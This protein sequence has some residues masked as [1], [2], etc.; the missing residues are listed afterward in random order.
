M[1]ANQAPTVSVA[2]AP[3][4]VP[5]GETVTLTGT[6]SDP[7]VP[8]VLTYLWS[9]SVEGGSFADST[10]LSTTWMAPT[11]TG[12]DDV[13][14]TLTLTVTDD[15]DNT[16]SDSVVVTVLAPTQELKAFIFADPRTVLGNGMLDLIGTFSGALDADSVTH[17]WTATNGTIAPNNTASTVW[18]APAPT[19]QE[20]TITVTLTVTEGDQTADAS[21]TITVLANPEPMVN[22]WVPSLEVNGIEAVTFDFV[23]VDDAD[24]LTFGWVDES[25]LGS[26]DDSGIL[27][28]T[29]TAPLPSRAL[30]STVL[31]LTVTDSV[32]SIERSVD[33]EVRGN[34][35][36]TLTIHAPE[37]FFGGQAQEVS[38][39]A[40]DPENDPLS[41]K[42]TTEGSTV[43]MFADDA[44]A[45]T[46][47]TA[48]PAGEEDVV[49]DLVVTVEDAVFVPVPDPVIARQQI[50]V[51]KNGAPDVMI[52][53]T[54]NIVAGG[55]DVGLDAEATRVADREGDML[56]YQWSAV[57]SVGTFRTFAGE[58]SP[59]M[60]WTAPPAKRDSQ[61]VTLTLT[62]TD[63]GAGTRSTSK[64]VTV[65]VRADEAPTRPDDLPTR[66]D[67]NGGDEE[68]L[69]GTS[70]TDV[71]G[72]AWSTDVGTFAGGAT[73]ATGETPTWTAPGPDRAGASGTITL[74][75]TDALGDTVFTIPVTVRAD[76]APTGSVSA[77][78]GTVLGGTEVALVAAISDDNP[79]ELTYR[80]T[81]NP[82]VGTFS[83]DTAQNTSWTAPAATAADRPVTFTLTVTDAVGDTAFTTMV[84]VQQNQPPA[85][86]LGDDRDVVGETVV[87]LAPVVSDPEGDML[88]HAWTADPDVGT[89]ANPLAKDTTWTAPAAA[90]DA[91]AVVLTLTVTDNGAGAL[92][93]SDSLTVTVRPLGTT[94]LVGD[95]R[96][97]PGFA[98][99]Y[100]G[101]GG[102]ELRWK[103]P[104]RVPFSAA[105]DYDAIGF[106]GFE[107]QFRT[108]PL[109][110]GW[111][112][113]DDGD[114]ELL[115]RLAP[116]DITRAPA[117][118]VRY[119]V[120]GAPACSSREWRVRALYS[121]AEG[122]TDLY[123][124]SEWVQF[125][126]YNRPPDGP[127]H[128]PRTDLDN[129]WMRPQDVGY[130]LQFAFGPGGGPAE[131]A[132]AVVTGYEVQRRYIIAKYYGS[133]EP[134]AASQVAMPSEAPAWWDSDDARYGPYNQANWNKM[135]FNQPDELWSNLYRGN[136]NTN[137][138]T[139]NTIGSDCG[140]APRHI[141]PF[142]DPDHMT[143]DGNDIY[144]KWEDLP[145]LG[146]DD[147]TWNSLTCT[148]PPANAKYAM[149]VYFYQ[150]RVRAINN[151]HGTSDWTQHRFT[152]SLP[153]SHSQGAT[154]PT[155]DELVN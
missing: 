150:Y 11:V 40:V 122:I 139:V 15:A 87:S 97:A 89:F 79:S 5:S 8:T 16:A 141:E 149:S 95:E 152:T 94:D 143:R 23:D 4:S 37:V 48:P 62:V 46:E 38:V 1:R 35:A 72:Y 34:D 71:T 20:Q 33:V 27:G 21:V 61:Q 91:Q 128:A 22:G 57:P 107:V 78:P 69:D 127:P 103:F 155:D 100:E 92:S 131:A 28:A 18:T 52:A 117:A 43:G 98:S 32:G 63:D 111:D 19:R 59:D 29:W 154:T 49:W 96:S 132:C 65:T 12:S 25:G 108:Q 54:P 47:W 70:D 105:T 88:V 90:R 36:P 136:H 123:E 137:S 153:A 17:R 113:P 64:S 82:A 66:L 99:R 151:S 101:R 60:T 14:A 50:T 142:W 39:E 13:M 106:E 84:T 56:S 135:W 104:R 115:A 31:V 116:E 26:F 30:R 148:D 44:S 3:T 125:G 129:T 126:E 85:V 75:V 53:V 9:S 55:E 86:T 102:V 51:L 6:A 81:D 24:T 41:Y 120:T 73:T 67:V 134:R 133:G 74:T 119:A 144:S 130:R 68:S 124:D 114:W 45:A 146:G 58:P 10:A 80:W 138:D 121:P 93:G 76:T 118:R 112:W 7:D 145:S 140:A 147:I 77:D 2:A 42:W 109:G 110:E 83:N